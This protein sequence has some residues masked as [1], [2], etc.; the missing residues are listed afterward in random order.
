LTVHDGNSRALD[1]PQQMKM[2][3]VGILAHDFRRLRRRHALDP[4]IGL[5]VVLDPEDLILRVDHW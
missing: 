5:E 2:M 3:V 1:R 4:L